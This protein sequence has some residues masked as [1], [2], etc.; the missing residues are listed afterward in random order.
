MAMLRFRILDSDKA[1]LRSHSRD[2][3]EMLVNEDHLV[4]IKPINI[5]ISNDLVKGFWIRLSNGKKY[6]AVEIPEKFSKAFKNL[7]EVFNCNPQ[8]VQHDIGNSAEIV[9]Q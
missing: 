9:K 1:T 4:S 3:L 6:K 5:M 8:F 7:D 2:E